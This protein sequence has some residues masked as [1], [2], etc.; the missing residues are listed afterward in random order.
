MDKEIKPP[1]LRT[2][3]NYDRDL[4]SKATGLS[5]PEKTLAQQQFLEESDINTLVHR[6]HLT[7]EMPT[8]KQLPEYGDYFGEFNFQEAMNQV[9]DAQK[10]FMAY[11][12]KLR[13]HFDNDPGQFIDFM[14][15][16]DKEENAKEAIRLGLATPVA[17]PPAKVAET[18]PHKA[19]TP[20][21]GGKGTPDP[22]TGEISDP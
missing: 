4:A 13:A 10:A 9:I 7:G 21:K 20:K 16:L 2:P 19:Q 22:D 3:Y 8:P 15:S 12:A 14:Q 5:C 6:F 17:P 18:P 11:P 1:F